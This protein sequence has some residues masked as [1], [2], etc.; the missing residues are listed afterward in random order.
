MY[1]LR[2]ICD[3]PSVSLRTRPESNLLLI[4]K[5]TQKYPN[6][7]CSYTKRWFNL[8]YELGSFWEKNRPPESISASELDILEVK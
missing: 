3:N 6:P 5:S 4:S 8:N 2:I 1:L 7:E